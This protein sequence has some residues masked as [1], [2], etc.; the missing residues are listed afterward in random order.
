MNAS[1]RNKRR[2][3]RIRLVVILAIVVGLLAIGVIVLRNRVTAGAPS[4]A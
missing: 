2:E 4:T 1:K 3:Q